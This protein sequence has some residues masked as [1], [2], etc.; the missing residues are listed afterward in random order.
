MQQELLD[1]I[2]Q[3]AERGGAFLEREAPLYA[4]EVIAWHFYSGLAGVI[5]SALVLLAAV[6]A[7]YFCCTQG[8]KKER[9]RRDPGPYGPGFFCCCL[10]AVI[11]FVPLVI[12][13][14]NLLKVVTAPRVVI[15][16]HLSGLGK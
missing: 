13:T 11:G 2:K 6:G 3:A 16:E 9:E 10:L 4:Q 8:M 7:G 15:V 5:V 14:Y 1:W 12:N